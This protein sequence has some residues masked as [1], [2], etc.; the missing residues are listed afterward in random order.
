M[1]RAAALATAHER[2]AGVTDGDLRRAL[3]ELHVL[4]S[5]APLAIRAQYEQ[6][7]EATLQLMADKAADRLAAGDFSWRVAAGATERMWALT[8]G[9]QLRALDWSLLRAAHDVGNLDDVAG[10][11]VKEAGVFVIPRLSERKVGKR[12]QGF[13]KRGLLHHRLLPRMVDSHEVRLVANDMRP[14]AG[15]DEPRHPLRLGAALFRNPQLVTRP[16][17]T[18]NDKAFVATGLICDDA[19]GHVTRQMDAALDASCFAVVWP[20]L[21][22]TPDLLRRIKTGLAQRSLSADA[23]PA[24]EVVVA[25][26][27]HEP[28]EGRHV[29]RARILDGY[30]AELASYDKVI[31]Y[32]DKDLGAEDIRPGRRLPVVVTGGYLVGFAI[33]K[34]FCDVAADSPFFSL[35]LDFVLVPSMGDEATMKGHQNTAKR[36]QATFGTRTFV[37]QQCDPA[38]AKRYG[39][40][41]VL[42]ALANPDS[43]TV[44][45]MKQ[46]TVWRAYTRPD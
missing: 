15:R 9:A 4:F 39:C 16:T 35:H 44:R 20:E 43:K 26:S 2:I 13:D 41:M 28:E 31:P 11:L 6:L 38:I 23:R 32:I 40:G 24:P 29:N 42:P 22:V 45:Q 36:I 10:W 12:G 27:W 17:V 18:G 37:V 34:D 1:D 46:K 5:E 14:A 3:L 19:P 25:G 21:S 33:C 8:I 7:H 30:G